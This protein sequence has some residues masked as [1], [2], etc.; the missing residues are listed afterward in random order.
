MFGPPPA[1]GQHPFRS[2][3]D[4]RTDKAALGRPASSAATQT[5]P[6][7]PSNS[8]NTAPPNSGVETGACLRPGPSPVA[9]KQICTRFDGGRP[10][11]NGGVLLPRWIGKRL[12]LAARLAGCLTDTRDPASTAHSYSDMIGARQFAIACGYQDCRGLVVPRF[13]RSGKVGFPG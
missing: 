9:N 13:A 11:S 8:P 1:L 10:T 6:V 2:W 12:G 5:F 4:H 7:P 3:G